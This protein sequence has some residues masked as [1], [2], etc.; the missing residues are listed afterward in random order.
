MPQQGLSQTGGDDAGIQRKRVNCNIVTHESSV[1]VVSQSIGQVQHER[2]VGG[3]DVEVVIERVVGG[4][5]GVEV[6]GGRCSVF[7]R[8]RHD[9]NSV[10]GLSNVRTMKLGGGMGWVLRWKGLGDFEK[11]FEVLI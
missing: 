1:C 11:G 3:Y 9:E 2:L 8:R 5:G 6:G 10:R 4:G 7:T